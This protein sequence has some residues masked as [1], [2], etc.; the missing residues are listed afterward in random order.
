MPQV[1]YTGVPTVAPELNP[2]PRYT[3]DVRPESFGVNVWQAVQ[4]L[5]NTTQ[6]V[7]D[8]VYARGLAMQD[9]Y[10]HSEAQQAA[11]DYMQKA[12]ELH[13]NFSSL[14]GKAAV[15]A[16]PQYIS[17]L[18]DARANV[19]NGLSNGMSAKLYDS[20]SL[21]TMGRTIFNGAGHAATQNKVYAVGASEARVAAISDRTLST[22]QDE[23]AF[24]DGL[25][26]AEDEVRAQGQ[27]KGWGGDQVEEAVSQQTSGLW[28]QRIKGLVKTQPITAG[29]M[30]EQAVKDGDVQ[31]EDIAKLTNLVQASRNTVGARMISHD[32]ATGASGRW[33]E[34][35]VDIKQA[36]Q[37]VAQV[38]SGGNYDAIGPTTAHGRALGKYQV[39]E[40]NLPE[41]LAKA[42]LPAMDAEEFLRNH[43]AQDQVFAA[44]F[45]GYMKQTGSAND[46]ASM[47][48]TGR[49]QA[50]AGV[51]KD[52][53]GTDA[54]AYVA[55][56]NAALGQNAPLAAK[57]DM[58]N[59]LAAEQVPDDPLF[60]DY[61]RDRI[62]TDNNKQISVRRDDD[63]HNRQTIETALMGQEG[64]KLPT[65]VEELTADPKTADAWERLVQD[66]PAA[67]RRYMGVMARNAKGDHNWNDD[68]LRK[69]QA[70]KGLA[71]NDPA[72][73][74]D[75]NVIETDLPNSAKREL[76]N[77]Q[78]RVRGQATGDPRVQRAINILTPDLQAAGISRKADKDQYDEFTGA[79]A[80]QLQDFAQ[81]NKR[82][83]KVD[84]VKT[85]GARL[86]QAHT[87]KGWL[88]NSQTPTF[89][90][91][92]PSEEA[93]KI[94]ASP[95]WTKLGVT[96]T[97]QQVQR[98][99]TRKTYQDLYGGTPKSAT[100]PA[101]AKAPV[102]QPSVPVSQ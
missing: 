32:V 38:E 91:P 58:G 93:E 59:R 85:I 11:S 23:D 42:G 20:E 63:F 56:F 39:T 71:Q 53:F 101:G 94:K 44:V 47:W 12:G 61:V 24:Q 25:Q 86:L 66:N 60:P 74:A 37:A 45:G 3:A 21:S 1:P 29:K 41:F 100:V 55:R 18:K 13:A 30:L 97:D 69:Y 83:P 34:G 80:D 90:I 70:F 82:A 48:L 2:Q 73:F 8:E 79:L 7:G 75:A 19:R 5:G 102:G 51:A 9:L 22:P 65:T 40:E 50:A 10:N 77:L 33:G 57:I 4:N 96:P 98:I 31:G 16:Y 35:P 76:I 88:W 52:A 54:K 64:G 46:A 78:Q 81:E 89:Q 87:T 92:V 17:D 27:L 84:E 36:A 6:K 26:D 95:E 62:T 15:D 68:S 99:Y 72:E 43:S 49:T 14:Q 28:A 67:A